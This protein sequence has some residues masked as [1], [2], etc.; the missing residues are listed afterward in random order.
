MYSLMDP[1]AIQK[2]IL[3]KLI[4]VEE[5]NEQIIER[6]NRILHHLESSTSAPHLNNSSSVFRC[7]AADFPVTL[8]L[9]SDL[10]IDSLEQYLSNETKLF[11]LSAYLKSLGGKNAIGKTNTALKHLISNEFA[12]QYSFFGKRGQKRAF[13]N[14]HLKEALVRAVKSTG[15]FTEQE[16]Q[17]AIKTWLKHAPQRFARDQKN[18]GK[19]S[20]QTE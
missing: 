9:H 20:I 11:Q 13:A 8:P 4:R 6:Q 16:I 7:V 2:A 5:Q 12:T 19:N 17:N 14:L 10:E 15:Q 18:N 1:G 3:E